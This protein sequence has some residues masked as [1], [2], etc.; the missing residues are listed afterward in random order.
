MTSIL[1]AVLM[2]LVGYITFTLREYV[3]K[4]SVILL[5]FLMFVLDG[6][7]V[8]SYYMLG[9]GK[10]E[11]ISFISSKVPIWNLNSV[12]EFFMEI[13]LKNKRD[14]EDSFI[15]TKIDRDIFIKS[16]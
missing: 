9:F 15:K 7:I 13:I 11:L 8:Q 5:I 3:N 14:L 6:I 16:L 4:Y 12:S 2:A 10:Y 1:I